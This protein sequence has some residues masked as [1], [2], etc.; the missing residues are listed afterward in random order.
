[1]AG[2]IWGSQNKIQPGVYINIKSR[3]NPAVNVGE[4]GV[5]A[6]AEPLSWGPKGTVLTITPGEDLV[7]YIGY[8]VTSAKSLFF[9]K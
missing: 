5:V 1:M 3:K 8:D 4:R 9:A 2:G 6:I 7:P